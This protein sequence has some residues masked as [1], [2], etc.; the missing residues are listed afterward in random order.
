MCTVLLPPG[1]YQMCTVLL[2][3]GG[4]PTAVNK[5]IKYQLEIH[6]KITAYRRRCCKEN[7]KKYNSSIFL[8]E[9]V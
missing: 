8:L 7:F 9:A 2:P 5:Y 6:I 3:P 1:G 4:Y